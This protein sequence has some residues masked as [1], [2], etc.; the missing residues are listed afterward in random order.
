MNELFTWLERAYKKTHEVNQILTQCSKK[1]YDKNVKCSELKPGDLVLVRQKTFKG[2][3][4]I[5][6]R[7]ENTPYHI[8]ERINTSL[9]TKRSKI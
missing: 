2:K 5:Q 9:S 3:H 7:W 6:D 1:H 8:L 4:R